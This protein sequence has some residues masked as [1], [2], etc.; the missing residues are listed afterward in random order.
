TLRIQPSLKN[1][2]RSLAEQEHRSISKQV[3]YLLEKGIEAQ[4]REQLQ[5]RAFVES[6]DR[7]IGERR[8]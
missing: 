2:V 3:I 1:Q 5:R 4:E 7:I 8:G 6:S